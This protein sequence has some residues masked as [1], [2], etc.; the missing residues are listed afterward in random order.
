MFFVFVVLFLNESANVI[1]RMMSCLFMPMIQKNTG[2]V[3]CDLF[4]CESPG[5]Q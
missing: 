4:F 5:E 1:T 3:A 2:E